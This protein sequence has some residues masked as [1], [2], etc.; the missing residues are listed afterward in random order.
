LTYVV[1]N[2]DS[3]LHFRNFFVFDL[4]SIT[5]TVTDAT[6]RLY[7][8]SDV[9]SNPDNDGY[10]SVDA[11]ETYSVYDVTSAI[12]SLVGGSAGAGGFAD[13]GSGTLLGSIDVTAASNGTFVDVALNASALAYLNS[14]LGEQVA[15]GGA[16]T[17]LDGD[18][19]TRETVFRF[20]TDASLT[21]T[22]LLLQTTLVPVP[23]TVSLLATAFA[24]LAPWVVKRRLATGVS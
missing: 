18:P 10:D 11:S 3:T 13:L 20:T 16:L 6:L 8:P 19:S 23:A 1:G 5:D 24:L 9:D 21:N 15:F 7:N 12:A 4:S 22:Q 2:F 17:T 14:K